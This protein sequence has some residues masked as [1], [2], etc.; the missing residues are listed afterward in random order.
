MDE[1]HGPTAGH[2]RSD[3]VLE[4]LAAS[5]GSTGTWSY[6]LFRTTTRA[7]LILLILIL[8]GVIV[9]AF[10]RLRLVVVA[11]VIALLLAAAIHPVVGFLHRR[12][13]PRLLATWTALLASL[14]VLGGVITGI[15]W[16]VSARW[17]ELVASAG[18]GFE[19]LERLVA[20]GPLPFTEQHLRQGREAVADYL[21]D[22]LS[23]TYALNTL[24]LV[25]T[26][27]TGALLA[28]VLLFFFLKDGPMIWAFL[29]RPVRGE[30]R[31]RAQRAGHRAVAVMGGYVRGITVVAL[32]DAVGIGIVLALVGVPL[33]IPLAAIVFLS[34][35]VPVIG[36]TVSGLFAV[37]ITFVTNGPQAALI[38]LAGVVLVQ[39]LEGNLLQPLIIGHTLRLH[40][41]V[42][43]LALTAGAILAGVVGA[44]LAVPA[45]AVA[46]SVLSGWNTPLDQEQPDDQI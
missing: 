28:V 46:W 7:L 23:A 3:R 38:V 14:V 12:G 22:R 5:G 34:G 4:P 21:A 18:R 20:T 10:V 27:T 41:I 2:Q 36:A 35:F 32:I 40:P 39:Q 26:L 8:V 37:L 15:V 43:A 30:Q 31:A 13:V 44:V 33:V 24:V 45:T 11:V 29:I 25:T 9:Y 19:R 1:E 42:I 6:R 17:P 16:A